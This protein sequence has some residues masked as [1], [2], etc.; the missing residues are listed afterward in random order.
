VKLL[1]YMVFSKKRRKKNGPKNITSI[2][3][4]KKKVTG[5]ELISTFIYQDKYNIYRKPKRVLT[6]HTPKIKKKKKTKK[7][8]HLASFI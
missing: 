8:G 6:L 5:F 2:K 1:G 7:K 4:P 3:R